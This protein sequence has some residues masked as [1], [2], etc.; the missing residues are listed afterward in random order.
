MHFSGHI[1]IVKR[2]IS[3]LGK[4]SYSVRILRDKRVLYCLLYYLVIGLIMLGHY[5]IDRSLNVRTFYV[6][7]VTYC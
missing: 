2:R 4:R 5:V 1:P 7:Q 6:K 3:V